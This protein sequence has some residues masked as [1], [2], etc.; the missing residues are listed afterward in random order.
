MKVFQ[1]I[2]YK[3]TGKTSLILDLLNHLSE[4]NKIAIMKNTHNI[5][6][7][8]KNTDSELFYAGGAKEVALQTPK[9]TYITMPNKNLLDI[10]RKYKEKNYDYFIIEGLKN[11]ILP[12]IICNKEKEKL[13]DK[14]Y[15]NIIAICDYK[16]DNDEFDFENVDNFDEILSK[17]NN[18]PDFPA[19]YDCNKCGKTCMEFYIDRFK[20]KNI[21]CEMEIESELEIKINNKTLPL[22]SFIEN[23]VKD[24]IVGLLKNLKGYESGNIEIKINNKE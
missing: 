23:L 19:G 11:T 18:L 6:V 4:D 24:T 9:D 21:K 15:N 3:K 14:Y 2:G 7:T 5:D 10:I 8:D 12:R 17:I 1:V 16:K 22:A 13:E 20:G